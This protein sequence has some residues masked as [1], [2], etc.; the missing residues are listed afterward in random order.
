MRQVASGWQPCCPSQ[1]RQRHEP[2]SSLG[3]GDPEVAVPGLLEL[4]SLKETDIHG[5]F[6]HKA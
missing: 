2:D 1:G 3:L 5:K 4:I 6:M